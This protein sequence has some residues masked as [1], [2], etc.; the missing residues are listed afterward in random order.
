[1]FVPNATVLLCVRNGAATLDRQLAALAAQDYAAPWDLVVVDNGSTDASREVA[2][3]WSDRIPR[4][5][6]VEEARVGLNRARNRGMREATSGLVVCCDA[7]DEVARPWLRAMVDA[8]GAV[9][10]VGGAMDP[11]RLNGPDAPRDAC[12]QRTELPSVFGRHYAMG[13]NL[14]FST[15]AFEAVGGF[16]EAFELGSDDADFCLRAQYAGFSIGFAPDAVVWYRVRDTARGVMRQRFG[17]GRGHQRLVEKHTRL[18]YLSSRRAQRWK[19]IAVNAA[20]LAVALPD[21]FRRRS[22]LQY[23]AAVAYLGGRIAELVDEARERPR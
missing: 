7:D 13:A 5:R 19:V 8:L 18:G 11:F 17:Y 9:D 12:P 21:L 23:L 1:V 4:M 14:G 6:T 22:R 10:L 20:R 3:R 15:R 16:D 2:A